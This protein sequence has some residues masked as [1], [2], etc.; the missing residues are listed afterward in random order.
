MRVDNWKGPGE[1]KRVVENSVID[2]EVFRE[3]PDETLTVFGTSFFA[4]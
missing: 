3:L 1:L 2:T 4:E